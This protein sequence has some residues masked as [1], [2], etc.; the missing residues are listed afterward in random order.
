LH[1]RHNIIFSFEKWIKTGIEFVKKL[2]KKLK[3]P[4]K[5]EVAN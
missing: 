1:L 4:F 3:V 5:V 2:A